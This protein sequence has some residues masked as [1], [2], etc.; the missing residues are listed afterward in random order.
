MFPAGTIH[1]Q[2]HAAASHIAQCSQEGLVPHS[3]YPQVHL[4]PHSQYP[5]EGLAPHSQYPR[6]GLA[7]LT[8]TCSTHEKALHHTQPVASVPGS[9][10]P[11]C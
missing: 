2:V 5:R 11:R 1:M 6:E 9:L 8:A 10:L 4:A 3:Q 7:P